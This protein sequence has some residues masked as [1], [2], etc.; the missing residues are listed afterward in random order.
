MPPGLWGFRIMMNR[1]FS[2]ELFK[3]ITNPNN[4]NWHLKYYN[5]S[6]IEQYFLQEYLYKIVESNVTSHDSFYCDT[7]GGLPF[8]SKRTA[9]YCYS[10]NYGCCK[11]FKSNN[12]YSYNFLSKIFE[13]PLNCRPPK[14]KDWLFC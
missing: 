2:V 14:N 1:E 11:E 4:M 10:S 9:Q 12:Y 13:C 8:P 6:N 7:F 3:T 5:E